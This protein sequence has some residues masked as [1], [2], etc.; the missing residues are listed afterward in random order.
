MHNPEDYRN[1]AAR[2]IEM[3]NDA[4]DIQTQSSLFEMAKAWLQLAEH[5]EHIGRIQALRGRWQGNLIE[6]PSTH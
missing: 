4:A 1:Y 2:C 6:K 3:A 5:K